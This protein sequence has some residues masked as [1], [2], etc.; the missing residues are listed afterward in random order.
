[1]AEVKEVIGTLMYALIDE[2]S[3][4]SK[5]SND[6]LRGGSNW[7]CMLNLRWNENKE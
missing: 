6:R 3:V 7:S 1:M 5:G 4:K 2:L